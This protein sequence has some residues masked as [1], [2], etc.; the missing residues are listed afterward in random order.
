[1]GLGPDNN[2]YRWE[3]DGPT[4][5]ADPTGLAQILKQRDPESGQILVY[6]WTRGYG[7][8]GSKDYIGVYDP[9]S[10]LVTRDGYAQPLSKVEET[11]HWWFDWPN[12]PKWFKDHANNPATPFWDAQSA[13]GVTS[14]PN[15]DFNRFLSQNAGMD[16]H[17]AYPV[18]GG[19]LQTKMQCAI[20]T[21]CEEGHNSLNGNMAM[22]GGIS[23]SGI[24]SAVEVIP[25]QSMRRIGA[26]M[27][28][29]E[30]TEAVR[31]LTDVSAPSKSA[32]EHI[33][34]LASPI[35]EVEEDVAQTL[36]NG[37]RIPGHFHPML[38][39]GVRMPV[40]V[41]YP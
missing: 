11:T 20:D 9:Q 28:Q 6:Y 16:A 40:H 1:M 29:A 7:L 10:T 3:G 18:G 22:A 15:S 5:A 41:Y 24:F 39:V 2:S 30:A 4:N 31:N 27:T 35:G 14:N 32:A 25:N 8:E 19:N 23:A 17:E 34:R 13:A 37:V 21:G 33:A 12:W 26:S 38:Q 36:A